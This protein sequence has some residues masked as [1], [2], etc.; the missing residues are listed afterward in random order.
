MNFSLKHKKVISLFF[1][2]IFVFTLFGG[3]TKSA[4]NSNDNNISSQAEETSG[5]VQNTD[6]KKEN[7]SST[8]ESETSVTVVDS[9]TADT[10]ENLSKHDKTDAVAD[11]TTKPETTKKPDNTTKPNA[12]HTETKAPS[13]PAEKT[14]QKPTEKP[15]EKP[16]PQKSKLEKYVDSMTLEEMVGQMFFARCPSSGAAAQISSY[17]PGGYILFAR[18]FQNQTPASVKNTISG[19]QSASRTPMLIGVDEEGGT[20]VRVSKYPAFRSVPFWSPADIYNK[21]G[22][23]GLVSDTAEKDTLLKSLGINVNLGPVCDVSQNPSDYIYKRTLGK[24]GK[25]TAK[26]ISTIVSQMKKDRM[27]AVLKHFP[28]YG[29][30]VDTHAG[31]AVDKRSIDTFRKNDF[32]PFT[33][34]IKAGAGGI[35][36]N[37]NIVNCLD[38]KR[39]ASLSPAVVK[40]LRNELGFKGV[41]MTDDLS[42]SAITKYTDGKNAAVS[43]VIAGSD[44]LIS[45]DFVNQYNAVLSAVKSGTISKSRIKQSCL[46]IVQWKVNL[47]LISL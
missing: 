44:M 42:M 14:A 10:S 47:G 3:C 37:H 15:T 8:A 31:I 34:G 43:A 13:K 35:M 4:V 25:E 11:N 1:S 26:C 23:S 9:E 22:M 27:G 7:E 18:D 16:K 19:Y 2:A 6:E 28:G 41:I 29:S 36:I 40:V 32:L 12:T 24:S 38:S 33:A 20:V 46:R 30:N 45:S 21:Y 39:P 5:T 17:H